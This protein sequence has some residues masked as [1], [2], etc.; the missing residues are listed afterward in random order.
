L[1][2]YQVTYQSPGIYTN[3]RKIMKSLDKLNKLADRF[4]YKLRKSGAGS[5]DSTDIT[6]AVRPKSNPIIDA[7]APKLL[8]S[9]PGAVMIKKATA[10]PEG[11][12][13]HGGV[14]MGGTIF[15]SGSKVGGK[16]KITALTLGGAA[17]GDFAEDADVAKAL[18]AAKAALTKLLV[19]ALEAEFNRLGANWGDADKIDNVEVSVNSKSV[20]I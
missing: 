14:T 1:D 10:A 18:A 17:T 6:L 7:N 9:G 19:P 4:E 5:V 20:E 15:V 11:T 2:Y 8:T 13:L 16:W 12:E 3:Q